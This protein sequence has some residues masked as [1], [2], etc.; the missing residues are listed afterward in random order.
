MAGA[1]PVIKVAALSGSLRKASFSSGVIR[2]GKFS[3]STI[4]FDSN[5][6]ER[7]KLILQFFL[8]HFSD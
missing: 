7:A 6:H 3:S 2:S 4:D 5:P 1:F 8:F